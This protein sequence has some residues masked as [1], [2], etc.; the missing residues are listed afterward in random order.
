MEIGKKLKEK[1]QQLGLTQEDA[2]AKLLIS[3]QTLSSWENGKTMPDYESLKMITK[4]YEIS[5]DELTLGQEDNSSWSGWLKK[6]KQLCFS[7][8][9]VIAGALL[10][11]IYPEVFSTI[12]QSGRDFGRSV[13]NAL[14]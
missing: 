11:L 3:R 13:V 9:F 4:I 2:A 12:Y 8:G 1:R 7:V 14:M 10:F 6:N 5:F